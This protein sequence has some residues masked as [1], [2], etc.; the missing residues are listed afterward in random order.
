MRRAHLITGLLAIVAFLISGQIMGHH[1]PAV[2]ALPAEFHLMYVSRHIYLLGAGLL[3]LVLGLY[4]QARQTVWR[5]ALQHLGSILILVSPG[6]LV[7]AFL[8]EP[9]LG[10]PGRSWRSRLGVFALFG[11][12]IAHF[13]ASIGA[14]PN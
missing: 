11:G 5:R 12:V 6:L 2:R 7:L 4:L 1:Q 3:N 13:L 10:L 8:A 9:E 14:R